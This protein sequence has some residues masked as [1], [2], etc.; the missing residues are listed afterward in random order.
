MN[1]INEK[2]AKDAGSKESAVDEDFGVQTETKLV[3]P[4]DACFNFNPP[5][6]NVGCMGLMPSILPNP[7]GRRCDP[8]PYC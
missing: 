8:K 7:V 3:G 2:A 1:Q 5:S 6:F 4:T